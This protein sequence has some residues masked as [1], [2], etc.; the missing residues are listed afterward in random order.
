MAPTSS[1]NTLPGCKKMKPHHWYRPTIITTNNW[2]LTELAELAKHCHRDK[3]LTGLNSTVC[4]SITTIN[5]HLIVNNPHYSLHNTL[6]PAKGIE[7]NSLPAITFHRTIN[8]LKV[9]HLASSS[10]LHRT[11][12]FI[13]FPFGSTQIQNNSSLTRLDPLYNS[14][15]RNHQNAPKPLAISRRL[16]LSRILSPHCLPVRFT[17]RQ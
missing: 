10:S 7:F 12:E 15:S 14:L 3:Q 8:E 13:K 6:L 4:C 17:S 11:Y 5:W 9:Q 16:Y 2:Q 1:V